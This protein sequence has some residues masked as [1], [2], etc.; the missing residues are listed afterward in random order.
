MHI[1][2]ELAPQKTLLHMSKYRK[3]LSE[4]EVRYY[5][6]Q[7]VSGTRY[8]HSRSVL[9]RDLKLGNMFLAADMTLKIGDFGLATSLADN[10]PGNLCG[11]PNYIA[12]EVLAKQG[13]SPASEVWSIGCMVYALLCGAPP[14]ET[15]SVSSTYQLIAACEY[16]LPDHLSPAAADLLRQ[17]LVADPAARAGLEPQS[18]RPSLSDHA[19]LGGWCPAWLPVSA[20]HTA[21]VF[22]PAPLPGAF[23]SPQQFCEQ[24]C[25]Y[26]ATALHTAQFITTGA[27][28][29]LDLAP[30]F[31]SKWVDYSNKFG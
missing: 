30:V 19:F 9:H 23:S 7:M 31:I 24:V 16:R 2:L 14:F 12:P 20:L 15:D 5:L 11:T 10:R 6:K 4:T 22:L 21:P 13:H 3:T 18:G 28:A 26:L 8:I 1:L 17:L 25:A 29:Y 27:P